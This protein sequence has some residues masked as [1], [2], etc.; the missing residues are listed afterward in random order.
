M[1]TFDYGNTRLRAR[2]SHLLSKE[3]LEELTRVENIDGFLSLLIKTTYKPSIEKALTYSAGI[4]TVHIFLEHESEKL[5]ADYRKF[6]TDSSWDQIGL[7]FSYRDLQN[8][9][10]IVRG[11]LGNVEPAEIQ[12]LLTHSGEISFNVLRELSRSRNLSDL[13]SKMVTFHIPYADVLL[14]NQA[15]L[16]SL[17]GTQI[18]LLLKKA[19]YQQLFKEKKKILDR[20]P[21]LKEYFAVHADQ[22]NIM[23]ALR[24][25]KN[26]AILDATNMDRKDC[27]VEG[28]FI[29]RSTLIAISKEKDLENAIERLNGTEYSPYLRNALAD[30]NHTGLLTEFEEKL[31]KMLLEKAVK[32]P[33]RDP[34]GVGVPFGYLI[35]KT[36]EMQNLWWI[37]KG[38]QLGFDSADIIEHLEVI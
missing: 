10:T 38:I 26:P 24:I 22:E 15:S 37:A 30:F 9:H 35:R 4:R 2:I 3:M 13:I 12:N 27:F 20:I 16:P 23:C 17:Q 36:N 6:Y 7:I 31:Q 8:I 5:L 33:F 25:A 11:V 34:I 18:E 32:Y 28:G 1:S 29:S 14:K 21:L 19:F